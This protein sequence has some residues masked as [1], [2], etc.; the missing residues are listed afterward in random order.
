MAR[1]RN[2]F[3]FTGK[4]HSQKGIAVSIASLLSLIV[5]AVF[6]AMSIKNQGTLSMYY[7]SVGV[8]WIVES[9]LA[10]IFAIQSIREEDSFP[11]FPRLGIVLSMLSFLIWGG[12]YGL[13]MLG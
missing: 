12:T 11:L 7:G 1:R 9:F 13:G 4:S 3:R 2:Q 5:Y 8:F 6:V 10:V